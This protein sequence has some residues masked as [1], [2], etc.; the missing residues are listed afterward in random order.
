MSDL[1]PSSAPHAAHPAAT[2]AA[3][4]AARLAPHSQTGGEG[5]TA[6]PAAQRYNRWTRARMVAFLR[7]LAATQSVSAAAAAVGMSRS[8][9]YSLRKRLEDD[10][11]A[12]G[13]DLALECGMQALAQAV[14]ERALHGQEVQH[15][16]HGELV[17]ITRR[18]DNRLA[19][20]VLENPLRVGRS[21]L[22]R[23]F[24]IGFERVLEQVAAG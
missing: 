20:W 7:E 8:A 15:F 9:A 2:S 5:M 11:F 18:Y 13:W 3:A 23:E 21:P 17:G 24:A 1:P 10:P 12:L 22:A 4:G 14:M 6:A 19:Q 16:Y